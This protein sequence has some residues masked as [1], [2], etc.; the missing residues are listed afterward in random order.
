MFI[1]DTSVANTNAFFPKCPEDT[2]VWV[3]TLINNGGRFSTTAK[4]A[5][6][7]VDITPVISRLIP[8]QAR[9]CTFCDFCTNILLHLAQP[10][11]SF[12]NRLIW[13]VD[14]WFQTTVYST[15]P[16][17]LWP[18]V[19]YVWSLELRLYYFNTNIISILEGLT[20]DSMSSQDFLSK[21]FLQYT[22]ISENNYW[23]RCYYSQ[24]SLQLGQ[25]CLYLNIDVSF[26]NYR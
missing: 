22:G 17:I 9:R 1:V 18:Q 21:A 3:I 4:T 13:P 5:V 8:K 6:G 25:L 11:H 20:F 15:T 26:A 7:H 12:D 24:A 16:L 23:A 19:S 14:F 10:D 2:A